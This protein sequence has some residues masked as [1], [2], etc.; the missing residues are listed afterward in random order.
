MLPDI[1]VNAD[2]V[3]VSYFEW[4]Q[5]LYQHQW[6]EERV[7]EELE[8]IINR[9]YRAVRDKVERKNITHREA[10]FVIGVERVAHVAKLRGF[11]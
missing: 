10:A 7:N 4:T 6:E 8:K 9:A 1:L 11:I 5:N 3:I 2:G